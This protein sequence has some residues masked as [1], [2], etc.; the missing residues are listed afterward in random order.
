MLGQVEG[1]PVRTADALHPA[2][3]GEDLGVPAVA[4]VVSHLVGHVLSEPQPARVH[5]HLQEELVDPGEEVPEGWV[6]HGPGS[7]SLAYLDQFGRLPVHLVA[8]GVE[9]HLGVRHSGELGVA[10]VCRVTE[11]LDLRQGELSHSDQPG[12]RRDLVPEG[13]ANLGGCEGQ[14]ALVKLQQSLEV[15]KDPLS[16]L[17]PEETFDSSTGTDVGLEHQVEF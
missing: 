5:S 12:P 14:L 8:G 16:G 17:R 3:A 10:L 7:H 1:R 15:D 9:S 6:G 13:R 4:G 2:V 11:M